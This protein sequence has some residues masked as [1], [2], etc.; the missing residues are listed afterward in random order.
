MGHSY[1][2]GKNMKEAKIEVLMAATMLLSRLCPITT[3]QSAYYPL[4]AMH[5]TPSVSTRIAPLL[6]S[7]TRLGNYKTRL[8]QRHFCLERY[9]T[10]LE[11]LL[12]LGKARAFWISVRIGMA[13]KTSPHRRLSFAS[14]LLDLRHWE[15]QLGI[16]GWMGG[17]VHQLVTCNFA[18]SSNS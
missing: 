8:Q 15:P 9:E 18:N 3:L 10:A 2:G 5:I 14:D 12:G 4:V 16:P 1:F 11:T 17:K 7:P 6:Q 13:C